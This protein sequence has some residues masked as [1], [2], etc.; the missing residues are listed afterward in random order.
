MDIEDWSLEAGAAQGVTG[1]LDLPGVEGG[2]VLRFDARSAMPAPAQVEAVQRFVAGW[3]QL[4]H[5]LSTALLA[6]WRAAAILDRGVPA[7]PDAAD[8]VWAGV[9]LNEM[10]VPALAPRG[11]RLVRLVGE[12]DW[13]RDAELEIG[14]RDGAEL[15]YVG[16]HDGQGLREPRVASARNYADPAV[17]DAALAGTPVDDEAFDDGRLAKVGGPAGKRPWWKPW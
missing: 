10:Q 15:L 2:L 16:P 8:D 6:Y 5:A 3:P 1:R 13:A 12:C 11:S 9:W 4:R 7:A 14:V 17:R